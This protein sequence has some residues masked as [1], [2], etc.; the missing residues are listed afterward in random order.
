MRELKLGGSLC[1]LLDGRRNFN[2]KL[3][4]ELMT[5][6][7]QTYATSQVGRTEEECDADWNWTERRGEEGLKERGEISEA[8]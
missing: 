2:E 5:G 1:S 8:N 4:S 7:S 6:R 3:L